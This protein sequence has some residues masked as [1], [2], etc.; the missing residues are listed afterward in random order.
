MRCSSEPRPNS[1][2]AS[3]A[4]GT[5]T[6]DSVAVF[7]VP[8]VIHV[9]AVTVKDGDA[10]VSATGIMF[11]RRIVLYGDSPADV[12]GPPRTTLKLTPGV[13]RD[14]GTPATVTVTTAPPSPGRSRP[15]RRG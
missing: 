4:E 15:S 14:A 2:A 3:S 12:P 8:G 7:G 1:V 5:N 9:P 13:L 11:P 10:P 6:G